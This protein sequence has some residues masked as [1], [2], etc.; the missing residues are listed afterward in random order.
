MRALSRDDLS[1]HEIRP[2]LPWWAVGILIAL[3]EL[4]TFI[5][6]NRG[7]GA[8]TFYAYAAGLTAPALRNGAWTEIAPAASWEMWFLLGALIGAAVIGLFAAPRIPAPRVSGGRLLRAFAG[9]FLLI[10]GARMAG[11]CTSG[12]I[13]TGGVQLA[14]SSLWFAL[15]AV[16]GLILAARVLGRGETR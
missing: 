15:F 14:V 6:Q 3:L 5:T 2:L 11:G 12:H 8:S 4:V 7:I 1:R 10:L 13:L 9:G 16:L